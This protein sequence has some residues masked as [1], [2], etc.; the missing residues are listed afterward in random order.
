[1]DDSSYYSHVKPMYVSEPYGRKVKV[2]NQAAKTMHGQSVLLDQVIG[3]SGL[4][5][6]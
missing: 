6:G 4:H 2:K 1:M 5:K 3:L